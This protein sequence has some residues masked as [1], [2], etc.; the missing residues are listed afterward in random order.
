MD[1]HSLLQEIFPTQGSNLGLLHCRQIL[2]YMSHQ[3]I[4]RLE[5]IDRNITKYKA[6]YLVMILF[7]FLKRIGSNL[8]E[9]DPLEKGTAT[10]SCILAWRIP[11]IV[12]SMGLQRVGHD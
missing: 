12:Q 4:Y 10:H 1:S 7:W 2:Y 5:Y 9:L 3:E 11:W 8:Q 6:N